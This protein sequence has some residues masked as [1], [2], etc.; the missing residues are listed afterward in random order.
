MVKINKILDLVSCYLLC[1][2]IKR[3]KVRKVSQNR[4]IP[5]SYAN[6]VTW[7]KYF[8]YKTEIPTHNQLGLEGRKNDSF[9]SKEDG[10]DRLA[11]IFQT[12]QFF[13]FHTSGTLP[14]NPAQHVQL[15]QTVKKWTIRQRLHRLSAQYFQARQRAKLSFH[16]KEKE[17]E[18]ART[19][20]T[21]V[22]KK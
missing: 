17:D 7:C 16:P 3:Q 4:L 11:P 1:R 5:S 19:I 20:T 21:P 6:S 9:Q 13:F 22:P 14:H 12:Q 10:T 15:P 8:F 18:G 2:K